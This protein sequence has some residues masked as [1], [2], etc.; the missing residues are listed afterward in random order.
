MLFNLD[1]LRGNYVFFFFF[2]FF[3][4][5]GFY[6]GINCNFGINDVYTMM[7]FIP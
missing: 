3:A 2:F 1:T 7:R 6:N 4:C 5:Q